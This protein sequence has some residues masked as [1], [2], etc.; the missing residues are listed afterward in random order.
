MRILMNQRSESLCQVVQYPG[1]WNYF[2]LFTGHILTILFLVGCALPFTGWSQQLET[3]W[4]VQPAPNADM[5]FMLQPNSDF[6][7]FGVPFRT[8]ELGF[9]DGPILQKTPNLF[10][11][12]CVGD[13][14]TFGT[15][16]SNEDT[17]PNVLE[18]MLQKH[19]HPGVK[20]DVINMGISAYS[21]RNIRG[22]MEEYL[23]K[24]Q[25][26]V[27]VYVFVENDLDDSVSAGAN[28][29]LTAWD[30]SKP[31]EIPFVGD[32]FA[33]MWLIRRQQMEKRNIL[34]RITNAFD[35]Q[36]DEICKLPPPL[37]LGAH[38]EPVRRW[39][40]FVEDLDRMQQI[41]KAAGAAFFVYSFAL[42]A[43][44]EPI[45][46]RVQQICRQRGIP[47]ASTIPVFN[48]DTYTDRYS[49][50]YDPHCNPEG[51]RVMADRLQT[52][53]AESQALP[54][55][56]FQPGF[57]VTPYKEQIN[58][59][60]AAS[61]ET[62]SLNGPAVIDFSKGSG[63][64]GLLAGFG[65]DGKIGRS[66]IF[67]L[68]GIGNAIRVEASSVTGTPEQGVS[69]EAR[70]EGVPSGLAYQLTKERL[71]CSFPI[72]EKFQGQTVEVELITNG[73]LWVPNELERQQGMIPLA[74]QIHSIQRATEERP[75]ERITLGSLEKS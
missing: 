5:S 2:K 31:Y 62:S 9:R 55:R 57:P 54:E 53:L 63:A 52:F 74:A 17:F 36:L 40:R 61:L 4:L 35:N 1:S 18:R 26:D 11:I 30:R 47:E 12:L 71:L 29:Y 46:L 7:T 67:R 6:I 45:V 10:R 16:V 27:V 20:V 65:I 8:N 64:I 42:E 15:G 43:H 28:G 58:L 72:P 13:S 50:G 39:Q 75:Q 32:D 25:P 23:A 21:A 73:P 44:S 56:F 59:E 60:L 70:I 14:V 49:L 24:L 68:G 41:T 3:R 37:I 19:A 66:C 34:S 33:G 51:H 48:Y 22:Q 69:I 38:P